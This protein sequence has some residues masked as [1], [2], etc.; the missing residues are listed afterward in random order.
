MQRLL[1]IGNSRW[2]WGEWADGRLQHHWHRDPQQGLQDL[3][4]HPPA[5]WSAVGPVPELLTTLP[6]QRLTTADVPLR[7]LPNSVGVDRALA[8]WIAW[9]RSGHAVFV[10][11]AGTALSFTLVDGRGCFCGGRLLA[12]GRLQLQALHR[13]TAA[14]PSTVLD[15]AEQEAWPSQTAAAMVC[16]VREGLTAAV[17]CGYAARPEP[18]QAWDL[19]LTG[20]DAPQLLPGVRQAGLS[21][22]HADGL[23]LEGLGGLLQQR[24]GLSPQAPGR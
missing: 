24:V 4:R 18:E 16:G 17:V 11:D 3:L 9:R 19:W 12:G 22:H 6:A 23:A 14:L 7:Q 5:L 2:H 1:L 13:G 15:G 21:P 20:G 10:A 8:A